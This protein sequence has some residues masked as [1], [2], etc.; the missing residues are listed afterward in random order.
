MNPAASLPGSAC[1]LGVQGPAGPDRI[2][3][4]V[5][6]AAGQV[7][8]EQRAYLTALQQ[9][10]ATYAY[11]V[12]GRQDWVE[13]ANGNRTDFTYDGFDRLSTFTLPSASQAHTAN[14]GDYEQYGYDNN[15]NRT[16]RRLRSG[17]TITSHF[18]ALNRVYW[19]QFP[20]GSGT[21]VYYSY[22]LQGHNLS[23]LF[24]GADPA[25]VSR[26]PG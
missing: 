25:P 20:S 23:A 24:G 13:D 19:K 26:T 10:Y 1:K 15:G 8:Y 5:Y 16:T 6:D 14:S 2:T 9:N 12:N 7:V 17:Q 3:R 4:L 21:D 11:T 18:D 22:D